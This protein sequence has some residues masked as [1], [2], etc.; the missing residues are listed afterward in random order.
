MCLFSLRK[1]F[2]DLFALFFFGGFVLFCSSIS[3]A[4]VERNGARNA[5]GC[6]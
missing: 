5:G 6:G 4:Q 1:L 2:C 3:T